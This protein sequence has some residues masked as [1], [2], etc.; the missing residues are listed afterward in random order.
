VGP[1]PPLSVG[2]GRHRVRVMS[3]QPHDTVPRWNAG[4]FGLQRGSTVWLLIM[5]V[6]LLSHHWHAAARVFGCFLV[7]NVIGTCL[8]L[9]RRR[10]SVYRAVQIF[11]P[12]LGLFSILAVFITD[13]AAQQTAMAFGG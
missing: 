12:P 2:V 10:V 3:F 11:L 1:P 8:W 9:S 6:V 5:A 7:P 4:W 13:R